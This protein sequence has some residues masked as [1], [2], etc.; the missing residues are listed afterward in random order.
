MTSFILKIIA[1]PLILILAMYL[2]DNVDYGAIWQ[3]VV[4]GVTL[5]I[6][7]VAME[8]MLLKKGS[9]WTS[10][11]SDFVVAVI[12]IW[13][14]SN[15]FNDSNVTFWGAVLTSIIIGVVE[16]MVHRYLLSSGKTRKAPA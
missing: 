14:I 12:L 3:P 6:V 8:Y 10:V 13:V 4:L 16:Y 9:L 1:L 11:I 15:I 2:F 5:A 7:G